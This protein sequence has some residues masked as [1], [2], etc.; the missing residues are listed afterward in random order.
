MNLDDR[1]VSSIYS[2]FSG[3]ISLEFTA[4]I[5][6]IFALFLAFSSFFNLDS[7]SS[8]SL[9]FFV[10]GFKKLGSSPFSLEAGWYYPPLNFYIFSSANFCSYLKSS[11]FSSS[12][13][14]SSP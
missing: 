11:S 14:K 13:S 6:F 5:F 1:L 10:I 3:N 2:K 7:S 4:H 8:S 12:D 9:L